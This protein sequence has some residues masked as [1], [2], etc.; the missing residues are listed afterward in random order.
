MEF[1]AKMLELNVSLPYA[2]MVVIDD[3]RFGGS[4]CTRRDTIEILVLDSFHCFPKSTI[5][6]GQ[7]QHGKLAKHALRM[8]VSFGRKTSSG[9]H[10]YLFNTPRALEVPGAQSSTVPTRKAEL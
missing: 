7:S 3:G 9:N 6:L 4:R 5:N 1:S 10:A 2:L 8:K